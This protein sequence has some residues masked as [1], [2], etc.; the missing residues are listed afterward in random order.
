MNKTEALRTIERHILTCKIACT[1]DDRKAALH[2]EADA[3]REFAAAMAHRL[4]RGQ[5]AVTWAS[6]VYELALIMPEARS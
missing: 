4:I 6:R 1:N 5:E 3:L 2:A